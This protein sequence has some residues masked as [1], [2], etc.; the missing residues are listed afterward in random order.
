MP[1]G[2]ALNSWLA[3]GDRRQVAPLHRLSGLTRGAPPHHRRDTEQEDD[4]ADAGSRPPHPRSDGSAPAAR[5][6][7]CWCRKFQGCWDGRCSRPRKTRRRRRSAGESC[8]RRAASPREWRTRAGLH[9]TALKY[10]SSSRNACIRSAE[11]TSVPLWASY[12]LVRTAARSLS[13]N[14]AWVSDGS[15]S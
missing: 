9:E 11:R 13:R 5:A 12:V 10:A 6:A 7:S 4:D 2:T 8:A 1:V 14:A 3:A 15:A